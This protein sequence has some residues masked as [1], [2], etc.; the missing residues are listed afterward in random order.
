MGLHPHAAVAQRAVGCPQGLR[1]DAV[2]QRA[3][4]KRKVHILIGQLDTET[5]GIQPQRLRAD[6]V[7]QIHRGDVQRTGQR[8]PE[9]HRAIGLAARVL[10]GIVAVE[11]ARRV[12]NG[13]GGYEAIGVDG[14]GIGGNGF[15][16]AAGLAADLCGVVEAQRHI[17]IPAAHHGPDLTCAIVQG[18]EARLHRRAVRGGGGKAV[19]IL[20][21]GLRRALHTR[22]EARGDAIAAGEYVVAGKL[23]R[24][25]GLGEHRVHVPGVLAVVGLVLRQ[26]HGL[27]LR[28]SGLGFGDEAVFRHGVQYAVAPPHG[29]IQVQMGRIAGGRLDNARQQ[30]PL[31]HAQ[32]SG[33]FIKI[34]VG[35]RL[36]AV[37]PVA[38]IDC[39][40]VGFQY[41]RLGHHP[42]KLQGQRDLLSLAGQALGAGQMG[43]LDEL[44]RD[45]GAAL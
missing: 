13:G 6:Q 4:G 36:D 38:E 33:G 26:D 32:R 42:F 17:V 25:R 30:R 9:R 15:E 8:L 40:Q 34:H 45:G 29:P 27:G 20:K 31:C 5:L 18:N 3:Q 23:Q 43:E 21:Q 35:R 12:L 28:L 11:G 19:R 10:G 22:I 24:L 1:G 41:L 44:L 2:G 37:G 14:G 16:G 7:G 39:V